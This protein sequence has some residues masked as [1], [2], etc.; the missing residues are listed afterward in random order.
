MVVFILFF[1]MYCK[2]AQAF[3]KDFYRLMES[4]NVNEKE[5]YNY[6]SR[7]CRM[8]G[9]ICFSLGSVQY[10]RY[11]QPVNYKDMRI[12]ISYSPI[13]LTAVVSV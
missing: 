11:Q 10:Y 5:S 12:R 8:L 2:G 7:L 3:S 13:I 4:K 1:Y 6:H 9:A